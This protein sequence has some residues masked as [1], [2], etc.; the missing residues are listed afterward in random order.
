VLVN[1]AGIQ[2]DVPFTDVTLDEWFKIISVDLTDRLCVAGKLSSRYK[3]AESR[4]RL[5]NKHFFCTSNHSKT[6]IFSLCY[7]KGWYRNDDKNYGVRIG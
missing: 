7:F 5:Y 6:T 3:K 1:N 4:R 2:D